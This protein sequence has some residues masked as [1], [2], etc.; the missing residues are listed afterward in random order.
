[1]KAMIPV[2]LEHSPPPRLNVFP[3]CIFSQSKPG[4]HVGL[5]LHPESPATLCLQHRSEGHQRVKCTHVQKSGQ[6]VVFHHLFRCAKPQVNS[7]A[8]RGHSRHIKPA[9]SR[10]VK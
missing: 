9:S 4:V 5:L 8:L 3:D 1:M 6:T 7:L 10:Q 2:R